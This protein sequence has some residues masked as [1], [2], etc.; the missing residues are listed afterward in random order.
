MLN[1]MKNI[2]GRNDTPRRCRWANIFCPCR[3]TM[4]NDYLLPNPWGIIVQRQRR[5]Q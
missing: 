3:A 5:G 1:L 2:F 4:D